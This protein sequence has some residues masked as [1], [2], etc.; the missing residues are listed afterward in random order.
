MALP[1]TEAEL[2]AYYASHPT[3]RPPRGSEPRLAMRPTLRIQAIPALPQPPPNTDPYPLIQIALRLIPDKNKGTWRG[4]Y[5]RIKKQR[6]VTYQYCTQYWT[7]VPPLPIT[8]T[9]TRLSPGTLDED[10]LLLAASPC[11]DGVADWLFG[12]LGRGEDRREGLMWRYAQTHGG[13]GYYAV[14][15]ELERGHS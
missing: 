5:Q 6:L 12:E 3:V 8:I 15:I 9:L 7:P 1:T 10:S 11:R 4:K 2:A 13:P 14:R